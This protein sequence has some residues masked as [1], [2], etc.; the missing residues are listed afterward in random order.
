[1]KCYLINLDRSP[2]RLAFFAEQAHRAG[3]TIERISGVDGRQLSAEEQ[4]RAVA[5]SFEWQPLNPGE[6]GLFMSHRAAWQGFVDGEGDYAAVFEDDAVLSARIAQVLAAIEQT[7]PMADV[8]KLETTRRQVVLRSDGLALTAGFRLQGL[9]SWHGGTA[10]YVVSREGARKLLA[11]T[12]PL[13]DP[14][15][16]VMFNPMSR[17]SASLRLLQ[18]SP[19]VSIQ[20]NILE[21]GID[22]GVFGTTIDRHKS[23]GRVFRHGALID[24]RRA[25]K[26]QRERWR[27]QRLAREPGHALVSVEFD[28]PAA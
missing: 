23:G 2:E 17:L 1:M 10:A 6:I 3:I 11:A 24:I 12:W 13:A 19:A 16:Q 8:I 21:R 25:W 7:R 22:H 5:A 15:D 27:R 26:K 20:K 9:C 4:S 28:L 14:V 18:V